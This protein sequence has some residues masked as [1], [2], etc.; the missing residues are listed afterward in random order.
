M[1]AIRLGVHLT[2][3]MAIF[4]PFSSSGHLLAVIFCLAFLLSPGCI[5]LGQAEGGQEATLRCSRCGHAIADADDLIHMALESEHGHYEYEHS[6]LGRETVIQ[7]ITNPSGHLFEVITLKKATVKSHGH[8][9][10]ESTW[11]RGRAW[12]MAACP[13]C[14]MFLGWQ[15]KEDAAGTG[16]QMYACAQPLDPL[17]L[18]DYPVLSKI[19][20]AAFESPSHA[21]ARS[22]RANAL[23]EYV[24]I[25]PPPSHASVSV[26]AGAA[27]PDPKLARLRFW[28]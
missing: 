18:P 4:G 10:S 11:S 3:I 20:E 13:H 21:P 2:T 15:F 14:Q 12:T 25:Q 5:G 22:R 27:L 24:P 1:R 7:G 23:S 6:I 9:N 19:K 17:W 28:L 26:A 16:D 8:P